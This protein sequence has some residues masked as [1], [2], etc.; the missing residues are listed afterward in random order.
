MSDNSSGTS[1]NLETVGNLGSFNYNLDID[2]SKTGYGNR[3]EK[4]DSDFYL[5]YPVQRSSNS[6]EDSFLIRCVKYKPPLLP[7]KVRDVTD[8]EVTYSDMGTPD[9]SDDVERG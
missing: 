2:L 1:K 9:K 3:F 5:Q 7:Q 4:Y 8:Y 6:G